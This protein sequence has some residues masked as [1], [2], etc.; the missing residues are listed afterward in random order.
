MLLGFTVLEVVLVLAIAGTMAAITV[1]GIREYR[2]ER[3]VQQALTDLRSIDSRIASHVLTRGRPPADLAAIG[4]DGLRDPWGHPYVY[5]RLSDRYLPPR[6]DKF[7]YRLNN[8]FDLYSMGPDGRSSQ[9]V[10]AS[11][12]RDDIIRAG[13]GAFFG[14]ARDY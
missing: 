14:L 8:D 9:L 2:H 3:D 7:R 12:S 1:P 11:E 5:R 6:A 10:T 13:D 4:K